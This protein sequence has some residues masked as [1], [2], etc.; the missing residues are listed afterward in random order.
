MSIKPAEAEISELQDMPIL[1][2]IIHAAAWEA[3]KANCDENES[4]LD[5]YISYY[6][7]ETGEAVRYPPG[8]R[9]ERNVEL[10]DPAF[11]IWVEQSVTERA[12]GL[13]DEFQSLIRSGYI[14]GWRAM[15]MAS[16]W[17][18]QPD[19]FLGKHWTRTRTQAISHFGEGEPNTETYIIEANIPF[20]A[21]DWAATIKANLSEEFRE[22]DEIAIHEDA[23]VDILRVYIEGSK[24]DL[25]GLPRM[26]V[27]PNPEPALEVDDLPQAPRM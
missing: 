1:K 2:A 9:L 24:A 16:G 27:G 10:E 23:K 12:E 26:P 17:D 8:R 15:N 7:D 5:A 13:A 18:P 3:F 25:A 20:E 11:L 14:Q 22:E 6:E 19:D 4:E 21:V